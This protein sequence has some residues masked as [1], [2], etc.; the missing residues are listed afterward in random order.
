MKYFSGTA[1]K[2]FL[3][4][5]AKHLYISVLIPA[6]KYGYLV[7]RLKYKNAQKHQKRRPD[8]PGTYS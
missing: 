7:P 2:S 4:H 8:N 6:P 1:K 3:R 5:Q